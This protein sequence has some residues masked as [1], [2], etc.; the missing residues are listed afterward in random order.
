M[1]FPQIIIWLKTESI[2]SK[3]DHFVFYRNSQAGIILLV[4]Y[5]DD[6]VITGND[7]I[8]ISSLKSFLHGQFHTK[9]L[10]MLKY[11]FGVEVM[12]SKSGI[13]LSQMKYV[14][15]LLSE[16]GKLAAKQCHSPMAQSLHLIREELFEDLERYK[17][18]VGKLDYLTVTRSE[19]AYSVIVVSQ[20][21]SSPIVDH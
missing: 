7:M 19:I 4:V 18:L 6:I 20:Y 11:F 16:R 12:R 10:V 13:F 17:R 1:S 8:G 21:M 3:Y 2:K 15:D 14:L 9:D 5:V